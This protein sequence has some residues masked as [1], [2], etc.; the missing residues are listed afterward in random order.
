MALLTILGVLIV[1]LA[2]WR[3]KD[4]PLDRDYT[5]YCY[6]A[7]YRVPW[8]GQGHVDIKPPLIHWSYKC[9]LM[10]TSILS[11]YLPRPALLRLLPFLGL[12]LAVCSAGT[13]G[14]EK[15]LVLGLL[16][17]SP[18]LWV[19]MAN[20]EWLTVALWAGAIVA[21]EPMAW[22]LLGLTPWA[23]QKNLLLI[24]PVALALGLSVS[25]IGLI[26]L[27][28]PS[29][30]LGAFLLLT[31]RARKALAWCYLLPKEFGKR[32]TF[33]VNTLSASR[34]LI[35]ALALLA[36]VLASLTANY[37]ALA[38]L[39][40][41]LVS[42]ASKQIVPHHFIGLAFLLALASEP[43]AFTIGALL[44]V[45]GLRDGLCL[46]EPKIVYPTTFGGPGG[47]Y[48]QMLGDAEKIAAKIPKGETIW[49]NG[50]E[51][52][53]YLQA[54]AKAVRI[55][56]PELPGVP[57]FSKGKPEYIV[58]CATS[59]KAFDYEGYEPIEISN[60]GLFTLMQR[61]KP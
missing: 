1:A 33:K 3:L 5:P 4:L 30:V 18:T 59:H 7:I 40:Y 55:E 52:N 8:L 61:R 6:P 26:A 32:R 39:A 24:V 41:A 38:A 60:L 13:L 20:T 58:H 56:I 14:A 47:H 11:K 12:S 51:N 29:I 45:W 9:W 27:A 22:G 54:E 23:N 36:P 25:P 2:Y 48:G 44:L 46:Y 49:V 42:L 43:T 31:G 28:S 15:A 10:T 50:M 17:A 53:V 19:H 21:P 35:P 37:W 34:L 57:D 16:F